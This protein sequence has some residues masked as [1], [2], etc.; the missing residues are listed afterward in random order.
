MHPLR[1]FDHPRLPHFDP[2]ATSPITPSLAMSTAGADLVP[3]TQVTESERLAE[4]GLPGHGDSVVV[5]R[6][7][8][9]PVTAG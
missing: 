6:A 9:G 1:E 3:G 5:W 2:D 8:F 4:G 7:S